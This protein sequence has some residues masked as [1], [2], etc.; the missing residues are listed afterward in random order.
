MKQMTEKEEQM[1]SDK[2]STAQFLF[3]CNAFEQPSADR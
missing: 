1:V 2:N 3:T